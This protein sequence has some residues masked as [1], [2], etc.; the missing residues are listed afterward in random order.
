MQLGS[1]L[2]NFNIPGITGAEI[3]SAS[4]SSPARLRGTEADDRFLISPNGEVDFTAGGK[5]V[6]RFTTSRF[7]TTTKPS[8]IGIQ[9]FKNNDDI[10]DWSEFSA[11]KL[12]SPLKYDAD[13][14]ATGQ[15][16]L[17]LGAGF[18]PITLVFFA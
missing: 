5:D 8:T 2:L 16:T 9:Q 3:Y 1:T 17:T 15:Y 4:L 18:A 11:A 7:N 12:S 6:V 14:Y 10:I 13:G